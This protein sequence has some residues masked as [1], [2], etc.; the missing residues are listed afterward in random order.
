MKHERMTFLICSAAVSLS[1]VIGFS[2]LMCLT[3][4]YDLACRP[5]VLIAVCCG[6]SALAVSAMSLRRSS[7]VGLCAL[8]V[9]LILGVAKFS[10]LHDAVQTVLYHITYEFS[11]CFDGVKILGA[12]GA[13]VHWL[14]AMLAAPLVWLCV[15][16]VCRQANAAIMLLACAPVLVLS[17]MVVD[18]APNLWLVLLTVS[19]LLL[20]LSGSVR[21]HNAHEGAKLIW[22]LSLPAVLLVVVMTLASPPQTYVRSGWSEHLQQLVQGDF[23]LQFL[24]DKIPGISV[25][26]PGMSRESVDLNAVGPRKPD[27]RLALQYRSNVEIDHLRGA[28]MGEYRENSWYA[29]SDEL[30][31]TYGERALA[32]QGTGTVQIKTV[33]PRRIMYTV[34]YATQ[35]P[36]DGV[37]MAQGYVYNEK[38]H[39]LYSV[40]FSGDLT[41]LRTPYADYHAYVGQTYTQ[42]PDYLV[43]PLQEILREQGLENATAEEIAGYVRNSCVYDMDTPAV[44]EGK[45]FAI[46]FLTESKR[47]YCVHFAT[48]TALLLRAAGIPSRYVTG[49]AVR[50]PADTWNDVTEASA[51]AWVE[52]YWYG[53]GWIPLEAT[54]GAMWDSQTAAPEEES[55]QLPDQTSQEPEP[56]KPDAAQ[57]QTETPRPQQKECEIHWI[58]WFALIPMLVFAVLLR[59]WVVLY[60]RKKSFSAEDPNCR[61]LHIWGWLVRLHKAADTPVEETWI[62]LAEKAKFSNHRLTDEECAQLLL[63]AH[64]QIRRLKQQPVSRRLWHRYGMILY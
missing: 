24:P 59:R 10:S 16:S 18:I 5:A 63:G 43:Q 46:H 58:W 61:A 3:Q 47:G 33:Q 34:Y 27:D 20:I 1:S 8:A 62:C 7:I 45:D 53:V 21:G 2:A 60:C 28:A 14:L 56:E 26:V 49:Y 25:S 38:D 6:V 57:Q 42:L 48:A 51:H 23:E 37:L 12:P 19:L 44:P 31:V 11:L 30:S 39:T 9:Y 29:V 17:L 50:G 35:L 4:A 13:D 41:D 40:P 32:E 64:E 55:V 36:T 15:W 22:L 54:P 52:Y